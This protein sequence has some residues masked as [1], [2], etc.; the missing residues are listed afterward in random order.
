MATTTEKYLK[1][2]FEELQKQTK[3]LKE[4]NK[5]QLRSEINIEEFSKAIS[6]EEV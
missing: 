3:L 1:K 2:I 5:R 6:G 4:I